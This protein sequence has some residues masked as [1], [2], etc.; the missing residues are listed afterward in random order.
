MTEMIMAGDGSLP[1]VIELYDTRSYDVWTLWVATDR[2][3]LPSQLMD[4]PEAILSDI[5]TLDNIFEHI[6]K[7]ANDTA[8][9]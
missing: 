7:T 4:E 8:N 6:R 2:K 9:N 5:L 3:F 1:P